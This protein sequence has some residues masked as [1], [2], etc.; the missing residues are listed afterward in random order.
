M[1]G[2]RVPDAVD[3]DAPAVLLLL[4]P[5][6]GPTEDDRVGLHAAEAGSLDPEEWMNWGITSQF[7]DLNNMK[8]QYCTGIIGFCNCHGIRTEQ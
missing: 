5:A 8:I 6:V 7:I 4:A 2:R 1:R 3:E